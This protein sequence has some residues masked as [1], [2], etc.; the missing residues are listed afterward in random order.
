[1]PAVAVQKQISNLG[2]YV[3]PVSP[4]IQQVEIEAEFIFL[5]SDRGAVETFPVM[6][7]V[8]L[9]DNA[10]AIR[11]ALAAAVVTR[12]AASGY[13]LAT[14]RTYIFDFVRV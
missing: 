7:R 13:V 9:T 3:D 1:M 12:G 6:A 8:N 2:F 11:A 5:D 14:N 4:L 10:A